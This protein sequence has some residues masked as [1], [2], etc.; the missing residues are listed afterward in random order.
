MTRSLCFCEEFRSRSVLQL[1][2]YNLSK[3]RYDVC[4]NTR[5]EFF[6]IAKCGIRQGDDHLIDNLVLFD[7]Q[8]WK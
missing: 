1:I 6:R 2:T 8:S 5:K 3:R 7:R 4:K